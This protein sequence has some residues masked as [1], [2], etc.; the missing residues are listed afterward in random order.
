MIY[1]IKPS[2]SLPIN[3]TTFKLPDQ[4]PTI[5]YMSQSHFNVSGLKEILKLSS[6]NLV[7][8]KQGLKVH[9]KMDGLFSFIEHPQDRPMSA[10]DC[11]AFDMRQADVLHAI[12]STV[13]NSNRATIDSLEDPKLAYNTLIS[14]HGNDDGI[15]GANTLTELFSA[16]YNPDM[17]INDYLAQTQSLHSKV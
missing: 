15:T 12:R 17:S 7:L 14:Q 5:A 8:W 16:K 9:L 11:D 3:H 13:D 4:K 6:G 2:P 1:M 10:P